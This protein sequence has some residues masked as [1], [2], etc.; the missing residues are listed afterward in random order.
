MHVH[1]YEAANQIN[2]YRR[3]AWP[4]TCIHC[5]HTHTQDKDYEEIKP[6]STTEA[7]QIHKLILHELYVIVIIHK[8]RSMLKKTP[9]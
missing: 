5:P 1:A 9:P 7:I 4:R 6:H 3:H 2:P 8:R